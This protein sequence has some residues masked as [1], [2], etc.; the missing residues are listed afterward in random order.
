MLD[1]DG[2]AS[3]AT[4]LDGA[5]FVVR[6]TET[7]P[8]TRR[9]Y[10]PFR[11]ST[12]QQEAGRKLRF[13]SARTMSVAQ[14]LYENG[15]IT[16]MR[17]D[18]V[19]LAETAIA[20]ARSAIGK[21]YGSEFLPDA[22]RSYA[23]KAKNAQEA[24]EAIR[25]AGEEWR[26]PEQVR[27]EVGAD[28]ARLY[29]LIWRRTLASQMPDARGE[30]VSVRFG[31]TASDGRDVEFSASGRVIQFPG[32]LK[33]Y[34]ES[35][36]DGDADDSESPLPE[37]AEGDD[38]AVVALEP[39]GHET[40]PPRRY[41][42]ASLVQRLEER[43]AALP[44]VTAV[45]TA[46]APPAMGGTQLT[47][48]R[49][50][51]QSAGENA[52]FALNRVTPGYFEVLGIPLVRGRLFDEGDVA[53]AENVVVISERMARELFRQDDPLGRTL[54]LGRGARFSGGQVV[55]E[56]EDPV[57]IVGIVSD[58]RQVAIVLE[59]DA[60]LYQPLAQVTPD[61]PSILVRTDGRP[62]AVLAAARAAV[63]EVDPGLFVGRVDAL[64]GGMQRILAA[65]YVRT[66][67]IGALATLACFLT[68][69]GIYGVVAYV[70]SDQVRE[71]GLRMALGARSA[72][73]ESRVVI[74][75]LKPVVFGS[76]LGLMGAYAVQAVLESELFGIEAFDLPTYLVVL[77]MLSGASTAAAWLPARRAAAVDPARVL[78]E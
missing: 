46:M 17:T 27:A 32:F 7:K 37:V 24:H 76:L 59:P 73:E 62:T 78:N 5:A 30:T 55:A 22:P 26:T 12:L 69:V 67:L 49:T 74:H 36:D 40:Q 43:L 15:Y 61:D 9:P 2:A 44:S 35:V 34:V 4:A 39:T 56:R 51:W 71:I 60:L 18:S 14:R 21:L 38:L 66:A 52:L 72:G 10:A 45:G 23:S 41:N 13:S 68:I 65:L 70:V 1:G 25:P 3:L 8:Y 33:V 31:A 28:E 42:E 64:R 20:T 29:D 54:H 19:S 11:T 6:S 50:E 16:Y 75:A 57:T 53:G 47:T 77:V 48:V 63:L 58:V